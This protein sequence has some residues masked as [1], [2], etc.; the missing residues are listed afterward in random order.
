MK[1]QLFAAAAAGVVI[2]SDASAATL[3]QTSVINYSC[4]RSGSQGDGNSATCNL[5]DPISDPTHQFTQFDPAL[6]ELNS[7]SVRL[8][9]SYSV[10]LFSFAGITQPNDTVEV[11]IDGLQQWSSF[12]LPAFTF[13]DSTWTGLAPAR[14]GIPTN[15]LPF[16]VT[17]DFNFS[18]TAAIDATN[19]NFSFFSGTFP[20]PLTLYTNVP[21]FTA[22]FEYTTTVTEFGM[23]VTS[24]F[25]PFSLNNAAALVIVGSSTMQL[26]YD[27]T[28]RDVGPVAPDVVPLPP[29]L[30][31]FV[32]GA[33][34]LFA[35]RA[36]RSK[37]R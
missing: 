5:S 23:T 14:S 34:G 21:S 4:D 17:R 18:A 9:S 8:D 16:D 30:P 15:G 37:Q 28:P 20:F 1:I 7:V 36:G 19:S 2:L 24:L 25:G 22:N 31:L 11:G 13:F 26:T 27:F 29:A 3:V 32:A 35:S 12:L 6:G 10:R 33:L